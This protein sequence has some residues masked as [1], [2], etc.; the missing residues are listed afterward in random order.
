MT[1]TK[2]Q[3][4]ILR[5]VVMTAFLTTFMGS[6]LNLSIPAM[7][8]EF[9]IGATL[10]GWIV[11]AYTLSIAA[12]SVPFGKIA[13]AA[14][15]RGVLILGISVFAVMSLGCGFCTDIWILL[16]LRVAQG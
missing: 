4:T 16:A 6:A 8:K 11:T 5:V 1:E 14:G 10:V 12:M 13:D 2:E 15:R 7:E 3:K 9:G